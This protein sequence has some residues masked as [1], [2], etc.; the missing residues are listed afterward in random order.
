MIPKLTPAEK[1]Q[2]ARKQYQQIAEDRRDSLRDIL[3]TLARYVGA[4]NAAFAIGAAGFI[5]Q[6]TISSSFAT[7]IFI[8]GLV[9]VTFGAWTLIG[10][11]AMIGRSIGTLR[12]EWRPILEGRKP[13]LVAR[14]RT[15][16]DRQSSKKRIVKILNESLRTISPVEIILAS[17]IQYAAICAALNVVLSIVAVCNI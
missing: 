10:A 16:H 1:R 11:T 15:K 13:Y 2:A 7:A 5:A 14:I 17:G 4:M 9:G 12:E 8:I 3:K 6:N